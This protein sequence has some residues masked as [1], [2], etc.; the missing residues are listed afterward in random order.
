MKSAKNKTGT[1]KKGGWVDLPSDYKRYARL[2]VNK[3]EEKI[4][5]KNILFCETGIG[6]EK[7]VFFVINEKVELISYQL[8][9]VGKKFKFTGKDGKE[10][11]L[12]KD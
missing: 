1:I 3:N 12:G 11:V 2:A 7:F 10:Y 5:Y 9:A 6:L 8:E 4:E